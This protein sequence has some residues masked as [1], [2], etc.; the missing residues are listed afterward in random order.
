MRAERHGDVAGLYT[1]LRGAH[2]FY[3]KANNDIKTRADGL[4]NQIHYSDAATLAVSALLRGA[5]P[6]RRA[7]Y[8][9]NRLPNLPNRLPNRL[10]N[11]LPSRFP[12]RP[13]NRLP[14]RIANRLANRPG[15][16][17][18][19]LPSQQAMCF[20]FVAPDGVGAA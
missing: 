12:N 14:H 6:A 19:P 18:E 3:L 8:L 2:I 13:P 10:P 20:N 16:S 5:R 15:R 9:P 4:V 11:S 17:P 1:L 7:P